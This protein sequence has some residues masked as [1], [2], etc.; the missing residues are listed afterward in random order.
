MEEEL[1]ST[2]SSM[3]RH[4]YTLENSRTTRNMER[5]GSYSMMGALMRESGSTM[6]TTG[7]TLDITTSEL[8]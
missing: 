1:L 7:S 5:E 2:R 3:G 4:S 6:N 8:F